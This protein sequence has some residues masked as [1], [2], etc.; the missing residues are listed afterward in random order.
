M[1]YEF[2]GRMI[3]SR[4]LTS[5][6]ICFR[7][8]DLGPVAVNSNGWTEL[9]QLY[10]H[11]KETVFNLKGQLMTHEFIVGTSKVD[12]SWSEPTMYSFKFVNCSLLNMQSRINIVNHLQPPMAFLQVYGTYKNGSI[13]CYVIQVDFHEQSS[14][15]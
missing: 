11:L 14:L 9:S 15:C 8:N 5:F 10:V 4:Q 3:L 6:S 12:F 7:Y 1:Y 13:F 2:V